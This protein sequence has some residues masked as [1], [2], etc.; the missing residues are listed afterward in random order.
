MNKCVCFCV[1]VCE[2]RGFGGQKAGWRW[3]I[4]EFR[5]REQNFGLFLVHILLIF[6]LLLTKFIKW[7]SSDKNSDVFR[8]W[9]D[10]AKAIIPAWI[11]YEITS[12]VA[13]F[14]VFCFAECWINCFICYTIKWS[15]IKTSNQKFITFNEL[16]I[17]F[18]LIAV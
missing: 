15:M 10:Y 12:S 9:Q 8:R 5:N 3:L 14:V 16:M 13:K 7:F 17:Y 11:V 18:Y 1:C 6:D 2:G 4:K